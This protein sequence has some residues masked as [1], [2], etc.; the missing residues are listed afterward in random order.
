MGMYCFCYCQ[1]NL[2]MLTFDVFIV[3][4][5][6]SWCTDSPFFILAKSLCTTYAFCPQGPENAGVV[7]EKE[8]GT[9]FAICRV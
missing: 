2:L 8:L 1:Q 5:S 6:T 7:K 9:S 3:K 4:H